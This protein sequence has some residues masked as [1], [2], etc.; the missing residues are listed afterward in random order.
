MFFRTGWRPTIGWICAGAFGLNY[1]FIPVAGPILAAYS[2]IQLVALDMSVMM[3]L[4]IGMSTLTV[5][6][7]AEKMK[8]VA[9]PH[10]W[11]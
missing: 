10:P 9:D 11:K 1:L 7:T 3:P 4:I 8:D 6:R 5:V 2:S